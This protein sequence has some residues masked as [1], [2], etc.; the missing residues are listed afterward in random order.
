LQ[1]I[2]MVTKASEKR[3][4]DNVFAVPIW[5]DLNHLTPGN[6]RLLL[7]A[8]LSQIT[9][10]AC[11]QWMVTDSHSAFSKL[12]PPQ[13]IIVTHTEPVPAVVQGVATAARDIL[14]CN[15]YLVVEPSELDFVVSMPSEETATA[16]RITGA[17]FFFGWDFL[18]VT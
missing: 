14:R 10:I 9:P 2:E 11:F 13:V 6:E 8:R 15:G 4:W 18:R 12:D 5:L 1:K 3:E 16:R 17:S 7:V